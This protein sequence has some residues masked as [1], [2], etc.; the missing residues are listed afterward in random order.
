MEIMYTC[1]WYVSLTDTVSVHHVIYIAKFLITATCHNLHCYV[2]I[3]MITISTTNQKITVVTNA[4][5][6]ISSYACCVDIYTY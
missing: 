1:I 3:Q 4:G 5:T 6:Q 2:F